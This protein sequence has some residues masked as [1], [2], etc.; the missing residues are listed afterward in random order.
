MHMLMNALLEKGIEKIQD[1]RDIL[2][3]EGF[4]VAE[5]DGKDNILE[6]VARGYIDI[7]FLS[8]VCGS[9]DDLIIRAVQKIKELD[10]RAEI[11]LVGPGGD[12]VGAVEIIKYGATACIGTP[13]DKRVIA[14]M[15]KKVK[16]NACQRKEIFQFETALHDKYTFSN[17]ISRNPAMINIFSLI[18][19]VASCFRGILITGDTGTGK[20][21]LARA[22]HDLSR[23]AEEPFIVCNCSGMVEHLIESELFGH[24]KGA[25]TGAVS[26]KQGLFEAAGSGTIFLDEIGHMPKSIQPHLLRVLQNG[27]FRRVGST[28]TR[29][30][31]CRIIA[32]TNADLKEEIAKGHFREDL[33]FRLAVIT[34]ELPRLMERKEDIPLLSRFFLKKFRKSVGKDVAGIAMPAQ[35]SLMSYDWPGNIRELENV[36]ERAVMLT[37]A[38]FI[39]PQ[40]LPSHIREER[41]ES[42]QNLTIDELVQNHIASILKNTNNNKTKAASILGISRRSLQ[43]KMEKYGLF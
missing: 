29:K 18:R 42:V 9:Y 4:Q 6:E 22:L 8:G 5:F 2:D 23:A 13:L 20:E 24:V 36:I 32:A 27:E 41:K 30:A 7:V 35:R 25:F 19:R 28:E 40:D 15:I 34:V 31:R 1:I 21:V 11:I 17:M 14:E 16:D 39:R 38:S 37:N 43:R 33:Y 3:A 12:D 10:P 26:N